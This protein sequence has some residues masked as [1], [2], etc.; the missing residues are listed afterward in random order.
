MGLIVRINPVGVGTTHSNRK[1]ARKH[2]QWEWLTGQDHPGSKKCL[3][4]HKA[5]L[6][7]ALEKANAKLESLENDSSSSTSTEEE[8]TNAASSST[9]AS[10]NYRAGT[11]TRKSAASKGSLEKDQPE[12]ALEYRRGRVAKDGK[13][14][15]L[16]EVK[17][18]QDDDEKPLGKGKKTTAKPANQPEEKGKEE[19]LEKGKEK[20]LEKGKEKPL[21]KGKKKAV[22][23]KKVPLGK[24]ITLTPAPKGIT[25]TPAPK[26]K[27]PK[28]TMVV[29]WHYEEPSQ[30]HIGNL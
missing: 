23:Q 1:E 22:E 18:E 12:Q 29:D 9:S 8:K 5:E 27:K 10:V 15:V 11:K 25:L 19:P 3:E 17:E 2:L 6:E 30:L 16:Q 21:G 26:G 28:P 13:K 14:E 7:K 24:G 20:P 4:K